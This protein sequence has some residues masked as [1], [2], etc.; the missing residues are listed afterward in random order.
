MFDFFKHS[1]DKQPPARHR[2][3]S[4]DNPISRPSLAGT[5]SQPGTSA[6][7]HD[8]LRV[9]LR[10][11]LRVNGIPAEWVSCEVLPHPQQAAKPPVQHI[12]LVV[13][14][15]HDA[16]PQ[17]LPLLQLQLAQNMHKFDPTSDHSVHMMT[18][19]FAPDLACPHTSMPPPAF[20]NRPAA[21]PKFDLPPS[22]REQ[23]EQRHD[24]A[25]TE[26][27]PLR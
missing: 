26:P 3:S 12:S 5:P 9:A 15:W 17:Y 24:F 10:N 20:W 7:F 11:T 13:H 21:K 27:S 18:W 2:N 16:L 19:R 8:L 14:K 23:R 1:R 25:P 6:T 4:L 22:P